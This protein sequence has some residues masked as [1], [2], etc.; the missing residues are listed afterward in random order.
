MMNFPFAT[1]YNDLIMMHE[2]ITLLLLLNTFALPRYI[3]NFDLHRTC[4]ILCWNC[5]IVT[6]IIYANY[7]RHMIAKLTEV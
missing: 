2:V 1:L 7:V 6:E 3:F 4:N 5:Y